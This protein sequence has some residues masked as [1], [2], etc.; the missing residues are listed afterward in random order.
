MK[1][2]PLYILR[3]FLLPLAY[4]VVTFSSLFMISQLFELFAAIMENKPSLGKILFYFAATLAPF[5]E[6]IFAASLMLATL[7]T[8]WRLC[9]NSEITAMRA[10]GISFPAISAPI[11][12]TSLALAALVFLNT[13][14]FVPRHTE[15]AL[16][17]AEMKSKSLFAARQASASEGVSYFNAAHRRFWQIKKFDPAQ[18]GL[19]RGAHIKFERE[20]NSPEFTVTATSARFLDGMW[21]LENAVENHYDE[22]AFPVPH[23]A[24]LLNRLSLRAFPQLTET[25]EDFRD[26]T[27]RWEFLSFQAR[28]RYIQNHPNLEDFSARAYDMLYCLAAP[29][30]CLVMTL[31]AI[32]AGLATGR[33]SVAKGVISAI[34]IFFAFYALTMLCMLLTKQPP[35]SPWH[36]SPWIAAWAPSLLFLSGGL[37][38]FYRQR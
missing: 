12:G 26:E 3:E 19:L 25:P 5:L 7:Y 34:G 37:V 27:R 17:M 8:V 15:K 36:L 38:L 21:W 9:R 2:L 20:N 33:Q 24:P 18:P 1:I 11:L 16:K 14:Y 6:W 10:G 31:F 32:P 30:A 23:P 4:C 13:E 22:L 29:W 28:R 35:H